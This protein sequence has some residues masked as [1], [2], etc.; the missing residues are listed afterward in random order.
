ML[1]V[2]VCVCVRVYV[3]YVCTHTHTSKRTNFCP[4]FGI[5]YEITSV[6]EVMPCSEDSPTPATCTEHN[7]VT[8]MTD[9]A[10]SF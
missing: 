1:S 3:W 8:L 10:D 9:A 6:W 4:V 2:C 5:K 7:F